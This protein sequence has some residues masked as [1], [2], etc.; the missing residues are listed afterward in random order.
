MTDEHAAGDA[1]GNTE[2][3][4]LGARLREARQ[5]AGLSCEDVAQR[6]R[7]RAATIEAIEEGD[8]EQM[9]GEVYARSH[10][11][12]IADLLGVSLSEEDQL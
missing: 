8:G 4:R 10:S 11:K 2:A 7:L 1:G 6:L 12:A 3:A 9:I 5:A